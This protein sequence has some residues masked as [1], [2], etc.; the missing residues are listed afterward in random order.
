VVGTAGE[1]P[2]EVHP[3]AG[4]VGEAGEV[5]GARSAVQLAAGQHERRDIGGGHQQALDVPSAIV[6]S[7]VVVLTEAPPPMT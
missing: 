1:N 3:E 7:D 4:A 6:P 5:V 2:L